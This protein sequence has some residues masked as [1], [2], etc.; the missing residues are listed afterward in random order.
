MPFIIKK[1]SVFAESILYSKDLLTHWILHSE[2]PLLY[3]SYSRG[4]A[5]EAEAG[6]QSSHLIV[7]ANKTPTA[8]TGSEQSQEQELKSKSPT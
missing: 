8:K 1:K 4:R 7:Y 5:T 2:I 3:L 6:R